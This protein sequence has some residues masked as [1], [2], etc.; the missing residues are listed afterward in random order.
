M[1]LFRRI[2]N[3]VSYRKNQETLAYLQGM[4]DSQLVNYGISPALV[5]QGVSAWPWR[6]DC[7]PEKLRKVERDLAK[8]KRHVEELQRYTDSELADLGLSRG[9]IRHAVRYGRAG[10]D[11]D[12]TQEAA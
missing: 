4:S 5:K 1:K 11:T 3:A 8:E 12:S 7:L 6:E 9:L 10:I 2:L